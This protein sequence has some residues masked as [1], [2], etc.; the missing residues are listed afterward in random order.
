MAVQVKICGIQTPEHAAASVEAGADFVGLIFAPSRRRITVEQARLIADA[1]RTTAAWQV[2]TIGV[3]GVFVN[4]D[5][6]VINTL[7]ADVGLDWVQLSGHELLAQAVE[8]AAPVVKAVRFDG[9]ASEAAWL[10]Q[11]D[12][13]VTQHYPLLVDAHVQ[14]SYGGAGVTGDWAQAAALAQYWP[15]WLAGGLTP[16]NVRA[17]VETVRPAVVDVSSGV[18]TN[19]VKDVAK[20]NAFIRAAKREYAPPTDDAHGT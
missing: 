13:G 11:P 14:G 3:V 6:T 8:V 12:V 7:V 19:G 18:E 15:V 17:A 9:D 16:E 2:R 20:V 1:A 5:P 4:E 10:A